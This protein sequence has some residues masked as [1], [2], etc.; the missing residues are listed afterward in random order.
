[1]KDAPNPAAA[2]PAPV[3]DAEAAE[4]SKTPASEREG[5]ANRKLIRPS[6]P[7]RA[8]RSAE[9][10][11]GGR[12][13]SKRPAP[14]EQ[15]SAEAFY[16][17]KQMQTRTPMVVVLQDGEELHGTIEWYDKDCIKLNRPTHHPNLLIYKSSIKYLFKQPDG[18]GKK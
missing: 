11:E 16:F 2:A 12:A 3:R 5:F 10:R 8:E 13:P 9:Y 7:P 15:T 6:L 18:N 14:P 17:Q 4:Q 1:M